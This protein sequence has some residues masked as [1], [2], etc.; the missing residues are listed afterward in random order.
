MTVS[1]QKRPIHRKRVARS[2]VVLAHSQLLEGGIHYVIEFLIFTLNSVIDRLIVKLLG[3][4]H[5]VY[6]A[7][8]PES[9][10]EILP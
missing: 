1:F 10:N 8:S 5:R 3:V 6:R 9:G 7:S 4:S 2:N